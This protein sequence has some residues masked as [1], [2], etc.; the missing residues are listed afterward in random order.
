ME[1]YYTGELS[2]AELVSYYIDH[3]H[4]RV[5]G[6]FPSS[7]VF[8]AYYYSGMKRLLEFKPV[9]GEVLGIEKQMYFDV[10]GVPFVGII[11]LVSKE[12][13]DIVITDHKSHVL[14]PRS[15]KQ[16]PTKSDRELDEY[17]RQLYLYSIPV[18]NEYGKTPSKLVF[19]CYREGT[20]VEEKFD[21]GRFIE[22]KQWAAN[23]VRT[24]IDSK[25][26]LPNLNY[27]QCRYLCDVHHECEYYKAEYKE[28]RRITF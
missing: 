22:A 26:W 24:I 15:G 4:E 14:K 13:G 23:I 17:L 10:D 19:H 3:F 25:Q 11:D 20:Y 5:C 1:M 7:K 8:S 18:R 9:R 28:T 21:P 6:R 12:D 2:K 27:F 16:K